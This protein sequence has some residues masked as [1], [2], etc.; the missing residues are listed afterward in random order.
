MS[1][2]VQCCPVL[3]VR[4]IDNQIG[5]GFERGRKGIMVLLRENR[6]SI[7]A[8]QYADQGFATGRPAGC[9]LI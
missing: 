3:W 4:P 1:N 8:E 9:A 5:N 6:F 2:I 7:D